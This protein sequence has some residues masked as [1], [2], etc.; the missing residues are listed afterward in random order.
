MLGYVSVE[1]WDPTRRVFP[2]Q[3]AR[4]EPI[5]RQADPSLLDPFAH[6]IE[7]RHA[8]EAVG[9]LGRPA[10]CYKIIG[11]FFAAAFFKGSGQ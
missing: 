6:V 7:G 11:N 5:F 4:S 9:E 8:L 2:L 1:P 10:R 3:G